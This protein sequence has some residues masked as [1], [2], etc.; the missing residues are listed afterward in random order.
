MNE[1]RTLHLVRVSCCL[2]MIVGALLVASVAQA[3]PAVDTTETVAAQADLSRLC[4]YGVN[5]VLHQ[6]LGFVG[7][8]TDPLR[9]G[10]Y[11]NYYPTRAYTQ[12]AGL[13]FMPTFRLKQVG[14][15][16]Y[17]VHIGGKELSAQ[18]I[19]AAITANPGAK[20]L[21]G[22]EPDRRTYQDDLEA[23]VYATAYHDLYY[24]IKSID[25]TAQIIAGTIVQPTPV[26]L[27]Y[28]DM[29]LDSYRRQYGN[30]MPVDA[31]SIHNFIIDEVGQYG[32][33][34]PPGID[35]FVGE[36]VELKDH[37]NMDIFKERI[38]RFR[39]WMKARGYGNTPLHVTEYGILVPPDYTDENENDFGPQRVN[40][41]M[42]ATFTYM[43]AA[44]DPVIGYP[45][46]GYRLVQSWSW[47]SLDQDDPEKVNGWLF[48]TNTKLISEM[49]QNFAAYTGAVTQAVDFLPYAVSTIPGSPIYAGTP[50]SLQLTADIGNAGNLAAKAGPVVVRFYLG[51]PAQGGVQ[52]GGDQSISLAGCGNHGRVSVPWNGVDA[53]THRIFVVV[54]PANAIAET[55]EGNN[56]REFTVFVGTEQNFFPHV[57]R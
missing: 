35:N 10:Y 50:L 24:L 5:S 27:L 44:T 20:W 51:N 7:L 57:G 49:G 6:S 32:A 17:I 42:N 30:G 46:D 18:Q 52:I 28:L 19:N 37:D 2:I 41:F 21:I 13:E 34:L 1:N 26:R 36:H 45:A 48:H 29:V 3:R 31:W 23:H 47:Y 25:P 11:S 43:T 53:G 40:A 56:T 38:I 4:R 16:G 54:D 14:A 8:N 55:N 33:E 12:P 22:N 15:N 9:L 39:T